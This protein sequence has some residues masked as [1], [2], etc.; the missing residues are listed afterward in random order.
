LRLEHNFGTRLIFGDNPNEII[1]LDPS[2]GPMLGIGYQL[3][4]GKLTL[5][6]VE[7][8][9]FKLKFKNAKDKETI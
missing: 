3:K 8:E 9:D 5:E 6:L 7:I 2:G 1:A 4:L